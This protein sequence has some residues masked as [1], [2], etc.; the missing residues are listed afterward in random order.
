ME[1][2]YRDVV[3]QGRWF[4][5]RIGDA[6]LVV[7]RSADATLRVDLPG[8]QHE[9]DATTEYIATVLPCGVG[10]RSAVLLLPGHAS[11]A[12]LLI[13]GFPPLPV[14]ELPEGAEISLGAE[15]LFYHTGGSSEIEV[16]AGSDEERCPRC[17]R[18]FEQGDAIRRCSF[19]DSPHHEG[20]TVEP[21]VP[22][23]WCASY[24]PICA[25]CREPWQAT[26]ANQTDSPPK[27]SLH[28]D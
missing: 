11:D 25:Q 23:L 22:D 17:M 5:R 24:D 13:N 12:T 8:A 4:R 2:S 26:A 20:A 1:I 7:T 18:G 27:D 9:S 19:C 21:D 6:G 10:L 16:F 3:D 28:V 14:T 15:S